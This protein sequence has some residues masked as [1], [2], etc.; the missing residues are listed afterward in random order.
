MRTSEERIAALHQRAAE[1]EMEK[2]KHKVQM[3]QA[4]SVTVCFVAVILLA[5]ILPGISGNF[6]QKVGSSGMSASIFSNSIVLPY[7]VI[8]ILAFLLGISVTVFCIRL[9]KWQDD[10]DREA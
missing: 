4:I 6:S 7:I 1:L 5:L 9:K 10:K 2:R 3:I 8:G